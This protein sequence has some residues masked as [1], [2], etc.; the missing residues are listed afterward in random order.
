MKH[1]TEA[2]LSLYA[3]GECGVFDRIRVA[4]HLRSCE[5][6]RAEVESFRDSRDWFQTAAS[7]IPGDVDW[8]RLAT[9]MRANVHVGLA[10]GEAVA[11]P[12]PERNPLG[13]RTAAA[14]ASITVVVVGG[15]WLH[16]PRPAPQPDDVVLAATPTG[17]ELKEEGGALTMLHSDS[18]MAVVSVSAEGSMTARFLD[19]ETGQVTINHVYVE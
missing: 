14:L 13:W 2:A 3:G 7:E 15:W 19:E 6:C 11:S 18:D 5:R 8:D 16:V 12:A 10:A 17:I 1:P 4:L 9:E